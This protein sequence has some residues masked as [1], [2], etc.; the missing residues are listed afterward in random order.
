MDSTHL[1]PPVPV[2]NSNRSL[3]PHHPTRSQVTSPSPSPSP[4]PSTSSASSPSQSLSSS[5]ASTRPSTTTGALVRPAPARK[6]NPASSR[7]FAN[8]S[9]AGAASH[10][11]DHSE[12]DHARER[13]SV[14]TEETIRNDHSAQYVETGR[15]PQ[16]FIRNAA[17]ETRFQEYP[18]LASLLAQKHA[19]TRSPRYSIPPTY[20]N[21]EELG[22][23]DDAPDSAPKRSATAKTLAK[24]E[25]SRFDS[26]LL[27]PP[28]S[29]TFDELAAL[30]LNSLAANPAFVWLWVGSGQRVFHPKTGEMVGTDGIG[31]ER[32]RELLASWGY[33]RCEDIV[34]LKTNKKDPEEDLTRDPASLFTPTVEHCLMGIRGTV[35][36]STDSWFVHCNV[37]TDVLVWEGDEQ[38]TNLKP[39]ELQT[40]IENFC[41]GTRRLHVYGSKHA[42][43]RGWLTIQSPHEETPYVPES[44]VQQ[45]ENEQDDDG[46]NTVWHQRAW[47]KE[48]WETTW[49]KKRDVGVAGGINVQDDKVATL[50]PFVEELDALRPKSPPP[51]N[52]QPSSGG[53]GRGRGAGLGITRSGL[54]TQ[55]IPRGPNTMQP[56]PFTGK[57]TIGSF[58]P[59]SSPAGRGRG[60]GVHEL[61]AK[62]PHP[63]NGYHIAAPIAGTNGSQFSSATNSRNPSPGNGSPYRIHTLAPPGPSARPLSSRPSF[64]SQHS[65][66]SS[67]SLYNS[68]Y[69]SQPPRPQTAQHQV[70]RTSSRRPPPSSNPSQYQPVVQQPTPM[71]SLQIQQQSYSPYQQPYQQTA[72]QFYPPPPQHPQF[73]PYPVLPPAMYPPQ[74]QFANL[75]MSTSSARRLGSGPPPP[76][77]LSVPS[78]PSYSPSPT[79]SPALH[80]MH[81]PPHLHYQQHLEQQ[82]SPYALH[83]SGLA[84]SFPASTST[85][86]SSS[87]HPTYLAS[88]HRSPSNGSIG[89]TTI[90]SRGV[91][92]EEELEYPI[93]GPRRT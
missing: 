85:S 72:Q 13:G 39:P 86:S 92:G 71:A 62:P 60:S 81:L 89:S 64:N 38:D 15:R 82:Q 61:P 88:I 91:G 40:L 75:S 9:A 5:R 33:R 4:T 21:L 19:L 84:P 6:G 46:N 43:R 1:R 66:S 16:N 26:I 25:P 77:P 93:G 24:L 29:V 55:A 8:S 65:S 83:P 23:T 80:P 36:R 2:P 58:G 11:S 34:W 12:R 53:L 76:P 74:Q 48:V 50:L 47:N 56:A 70:H 52:G 90:A 35:R 30:P 67:V 41:L 18:K 7:N 69:T 20:L 3:N 28:S 63:I 42:L 37:D 44:K 22:N 54:V 79:P 78:T 49:K 10:L 31:L 73:N 59:G 51:R 32:G 57:P 17:V 27:T 14:P 68:Q 45:V 87:Y